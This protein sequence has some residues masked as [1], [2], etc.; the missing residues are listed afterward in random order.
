MS[1]VYW[2]FL[3][4]KNCPTTSTLTLVLLLVF[5]Q[6]DHSIHPLLTSASASWHGMA[7]RWQIHFNFIYGASNSNTDPSEMRCYDVHFQFLSYY[8]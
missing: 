5:Y 4:D 1:K 3:D 6:A 8:H 7:W 2:A